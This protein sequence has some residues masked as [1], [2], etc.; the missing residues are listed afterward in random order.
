MRDRCEIRLA[1]TGGQGAI[2]A[3]IVLAAA[4]TRDGK[5]VVQ[6]Q[7]Y[8]PEARGGASRSEVVISNREIDFPKVLAPN[9]TVC[10]S[11]EACDRYAR[12]TVRGGLLILDTDRV[13]RAP[14][15]RAVGLPL[16]SLA[17]QSAG[18]EVAANIVALGV[19]GGITDIVSR[20]SL[21]RAV[22]EHAPRGTVDA[23]LEALDA[24]YAA[25]ARFIQEHS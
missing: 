4:A 22:R 5:N 7:S 19:L 16:A 21:E 1:G 23:N 10:L 13:T 6:S 15:V 8:G 9:V 18:R 3:G 2:L 24:G 11:Q 17:Q 14:T 25:A 12:R 20:A